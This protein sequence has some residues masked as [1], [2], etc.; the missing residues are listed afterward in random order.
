M[1]APVNVSLSSGGKG[2]VMAVPSVQAY[3]SDVSTP[4]VNYLPPTSG[5]PSS[6]WTTSGAF[7][8]FTLPRSVGVLNNVALR[9]QITATAAATNV[10]AVPFWI[11]QCEVY[12]GGSQIEVVYPNELYNEVIGFRGFE[13][14][15]TEG[16][17]LNYDGSSLS[18]SGYNAVAD[19]GSTTVGSIEGSVKTVP[20]GTS[21][22]YLPLPTC[23]TTCKLYVA[24]VEEDVRYRVYFPPNL[25]PSTVSCAAIV[26]VIEEDCGSMVEKTKWEAAHKSGIVY[27]TVVRQRQNNTITKSGDADVNVELTGLSGS[28]AG[29]VVYAGPPVV[30]SYSGTTTD[31]QTGLIVPTN[32]LLSERYKIDT[33]LELDDAMGAKRTEELRTDELASFTWYS[34]IATNFGNKNNTYLIP[35]S[36]AFRQA[37]QEGINRGG[38]VMKGNDRLVIR[39]DNINPNSTAAE[40]WNLTVVNYCYQALVF[41]GKKL[42]NVIRKISP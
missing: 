22:Y 25:F 3:P 31:L 36:S 16:Q 10:P 32:Q 5:Q 1:P 15:S 19:Q 42:T 17:F 40:T 27:N 4:K 8:D 11:Q 2:V 7:L 35:F 14:L 26:L 21:Y 18:S 38:L 29:L 12:I 41:K 39:G 24:G 33:S 28:S 37:V 34:H 9:F 23:L 30:P 20:V 13:E 6:A